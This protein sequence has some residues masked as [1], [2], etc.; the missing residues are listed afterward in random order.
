MIGFLIDSEGGKGFGGCCVLLIGATVDRWH[1]KD[2]WVN[3]TCAP[4]WQ[5]AIGW[6]FFFK[7]K[8]PVIK[9]KHL[10]VIFVCIILTFFMQLPKR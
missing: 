2:G 5:H 3:H 8:H 9:N 1:T 7:K 4:Q 10:F 6:S